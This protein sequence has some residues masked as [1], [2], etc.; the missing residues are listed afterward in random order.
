MNRALQSLSQTSV[1]SRLDS[2]R[3]HRLWLG[4]GDWSGSDVMMRPQRRRSSLARFITGSWA[5][6]AVLVCLLVSPAVAAVPER[7]GSQPSEGHEPKHL[8][9]SDPSSDLE[10]DVA[11]E[12]LFHLTPEWLRAAIANEHPAPSLPPAHWRQLISPAI[13]AANA[14]ANQ[15]KNRSCA[16]YSA[17]VER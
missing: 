15:G 16:G 2:M 14:E 5:L 6:V 4:R 8:D 3:L 12:A 7:S 9:L 17:T 11:I 13:A 10:Q 1:I